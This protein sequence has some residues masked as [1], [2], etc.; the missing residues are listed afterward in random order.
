[1]KQK[2]GIFVDARGIDA[3]WDDRSKVS[4]PGLVREGVN[5][6]FEPK[7]GFPVHIFFWISLGL[8]L[9]MLRLCMHFHLSDT[10][11]SDSRSCAHFVLESYQGC[12]SRKDRRAMKP[13]GNQCICVTNHGGAFCP[14]RFMVWL[15]Y[16][17]GSKSKARKT[18]GYWSFQN[19]PIS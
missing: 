6:F 16:G 8:L 10:N 2:W 17:P 9:G 13:N 1:M 5:F 7:I 4:G 11:G 19:S 3:S 15:A 14:F 12:L 18:H